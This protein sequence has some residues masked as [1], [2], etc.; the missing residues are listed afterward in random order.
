[1]R[2]SDTGQR[3]DVDA[4]LH[5]GG[6]GQHVDGSGRISTLAES[7]VLKQQ[8]VLLRFGEYVLVLGGVQL[9]GVLGGDESERRL[10]RI[11]EGVRDGIS[12][13]AFA[14]QEDSIALRV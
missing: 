10:G 11:D 1:M 8:F 3:A 5:G 7:D 6:A 14:G 9:C 12:I 2:S 4:D 13:E